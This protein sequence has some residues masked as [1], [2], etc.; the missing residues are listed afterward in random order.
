[1]TKDEI[2]RMFYN[3]PDLELLFMDG[4]DDCIAG[5]MER[6]GQD[7]IVCYDKFKVL[8]KLQADPGETKCFFCEKELPQTQ[9]SQCDDCGIITTDLISKSDHHGGTKTVCR[10]RNDCHRRNP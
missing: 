3:C 7:P 1:M 6:F 5:V 9:G 2:L 4:F 8:A 10:D